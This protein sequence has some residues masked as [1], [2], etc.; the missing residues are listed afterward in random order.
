MVYY[1]NVTKFLIAQNGY[2]QYSHKLNEFTASITA[3][4]SP[5][6]ITGEMGRLNS[7]ACSCSLTGSAKEAYSAIAC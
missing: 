5:G 1:A 4:T 3:V 7:V 2:A 6:D